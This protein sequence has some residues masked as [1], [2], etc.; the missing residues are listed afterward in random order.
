MTMQGFI[1]RSIDRP[2]AELI[3]P[4]MDLSVAT[5]YEACGGKNLLD[6]G[7]H[8]LYSGIKVCGPAITCIVEP[9]DNLSVHKALSIAQ[10]GDVVIVDGGGHLEVALWGKIMSQAS[11]ARG[12]KGVVVNGAVRDIAEIRMLGFPVWC[13]GVCAAGPSKERV[14]AVNI[15]VRFGKTVIDP[16]DLILADD[17][18]VVVVPKSEL[19]EVLKAGQKRINTEAD[20]A[21][22]LQEGETTIQLFGLE[23]T[24][25]KLTLYEWDMSYQEWT[26][27]VISEERSGNM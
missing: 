5:V 19:V 10:A 25:S 7:I 8:S 15:P 18:G 24:L 27:R 6:P 11:I 26:K 16:G 21:E 12:V 14:G 9:G 4:F 22:H 13:R 2:P 17:D 20:F 3:D 1:F 23:N